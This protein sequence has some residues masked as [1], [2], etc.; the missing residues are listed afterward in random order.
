M[1]LAFVAA[2]AVVTPLTHLQDKSQEMLQRVIDAF[3]L[4]GRRTY[5][6]LGNHW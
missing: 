2:A 6:L 3:Q 1:H 5:S 4:S